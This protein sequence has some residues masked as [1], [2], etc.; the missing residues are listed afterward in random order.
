MKKI[1]LL[2][3]IML[4]S[5]SVFATES[6]LESKE[7]SVDI[8]AKVVQ[9]LDIKTSPLDFGMLIPGERKYG[10]TAGV[11]NISG[12]EGENIKLFVKESDE[13][14]Y[15]VNSRENNHYNVI[16]TTGNGQEEN[17]KLPTELSIVTPG[18]EGDRGEEGIYI[19]E[20]GGK[21][22]FWVNGYANAKANQAS[23]EYK[24]K[25]YVKAMYQ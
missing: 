21:K 4:V 14:S 22:E 3:G 17:Q 10:D 9:P 5:A 18:V 8:L 20:A 11:V 16:L 24:G 2:A 7:A 12:T 15:V 13:S 6:T 25:I 1:F 19:L 23:G